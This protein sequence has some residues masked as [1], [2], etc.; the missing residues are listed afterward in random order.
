[1]GTSAITGINLGVPAHQRNFVFPDLSSGILTVTHNLN[2]QY[3]SVTVFDNNNLLIIPDDVDAISTTQLTIDLT[4]FGSFGGAWRAVIVNTGANVNNIASDLNISGQITDD[5]LVFGGAS[6]VRKEAA[7]FYTVI[8][9]DTL[10]IA[11][12][13]SVTII[14]FDSEVFDVGSNFDTGA[15]T[16]TA[17]VTGHYFLSASASLKNIDAGAVN[18]TLEILTTNRILGQTQDLTTLRAASRWGLQVQGVFDMTAGH[19]ALVQAR[20]SSGSPTTDVDDGTAVATATHFS[21]Y[22]IA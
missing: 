7:L 21:G 1:M 5:R 22:L 4:S 3:V 2:S 11:I 14:E 9:G 19:T 18:L 17:P 8:T 12:S 15:F 20:Q 13:P 16:F 6:W 10:N